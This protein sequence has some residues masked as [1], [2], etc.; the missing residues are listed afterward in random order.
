[1]A[2]GP[3]RDAGPDGGSPTDRGRG[4][5]ES[6]ST[7]GVT[8]GSTGSPA[9]ALQAAL[10]YRFG[11]PTLLTRALT[12]PSFAHEHPPALGTEALAFL[13]D[14]VLGLVV[15]EALYRETPAAGPGP[16]TQERARVVSGRGLAARAVAL[17]LGQALRLGRGEDQAGGREKESILAS[18]LEAV[19][20]AMFLDGGLDAVRRAGPWLV[21]GGAGEPGSLPSRV[22]P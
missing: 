4:A 5:D 14:A 20:G 7:D 12:H 22:V 6:G 18:A 21:P 13:G 11:D 8:G 19:V 2:A 3:G 17:R 9:E 10:R 1:M 16:L 15:A